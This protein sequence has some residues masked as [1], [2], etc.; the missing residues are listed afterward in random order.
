MT[1][2]EGREATPQERVH[3]ALKAVWLD[4]AER[5]ITASVDEHVA[6][7]TAAALAAFM[8]SPAREQTDA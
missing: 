4:R 1:A 2:N 5:H 6:A 7:L 8:S 3:A